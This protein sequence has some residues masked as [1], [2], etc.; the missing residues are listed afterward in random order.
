MDWVEVRRTSALSDKT[1]AISKKCG[2]IRSAQTIRVARDATISV[3]IPS[4][5]RVWRPTNEGT[6]VVESKFLTF[7]RLGIAV[8]AVWG[9]QIHAQTPAKYEI[10]IT[11]ARDVAHVEAQLTLE[12]GRLRMGAGIFADDIPGGL[13]AFVKKL[14]VLGPDSKPLAVEGPRNAAW[15]IEN[16]PVGPVTLRYDLRLEHDAHSW[17]F[18]ADEIAYKRE[19]CLFFVSRSLFVWPPGIGAAEVRFRLPKGWKAS[20]PWEPLPGEVNAFSLSGD[21]EMAESCLLL[22]THLERE[23][24]V[25]ETVVTMALGQSVQAHTEE[26]DEC[27]GKSLDAFRTIFDD[28]P[29]GRFLMV[30]NQVDKGQ[31]GAGAFP[32]SISVLAP[33]RI[34]G[35]NK[36]LL[37]GAISHEILHLWNGERLRPAGQME[38]FKEGFTDHLTWR[39]LHEQGVIDEKRFLQQFGRHL[40]SYVNRV[41]ESPIAD[42]GNDKRKFYE[43]VYDGGASAALC[44]DAEIVRAT[45]GEKGLVDFM[46][47]LY[48]RTAAV[49]KPY[50]MEDLIAVATEVAGTDMSG[51]FERY[52]VGV[53]TLPIEESL[54]TLGFLWERKQT[55]ERVVYT[56]SRR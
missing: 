25:G 56:L 51:F 17:P 34:E 37:V 29:M 1:V 32:H 22:G 14:E 10:T 20:T 40:S 7:V 47:T 53:E 44:L 45:D 46:R 12:R 28:A 36:D 54:A 9:H 8:V 18:G 43:L 35:A 39:V 15:R 11:G 48:A 24:R 41:G 6:S 42:A 55:G 16:V 33:Q 50:T 13:A 38:W 21:D 4:N 3:V 49:E 19:D 23:V 30:M 27:I 2:R 31:W 5:N 26:F 52:V